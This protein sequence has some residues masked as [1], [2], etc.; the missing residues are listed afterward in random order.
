MKFILL[1]SCLG[2]ALIGISQNL[3]KEYLKAYTFLDSVRNHDFTVT[4]FVKFI[5]SS[6]FHNDSVVLTDTLVP[7]EVTSNRLFYQRF[8]FVSYVDKRLDSAFESQL[9]RKHYLIFSKPEHN[10][11]LVELREGSLNLANPDKP[12]FG[13]AEKYLFIFNEQ[14]DLLRVVNHA[15]IYN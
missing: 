15:I 4:S 6:P 10:I 3:P 14:K 12:Y 2:F 13:M 1:F 9:N 11:L 7:S 8:L 5:G